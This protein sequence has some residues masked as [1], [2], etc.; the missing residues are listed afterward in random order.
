[1]SI[2][3]DNH[4]KTYNI[5]APN[6]LFRLKNPL[7]TRVK[8]CKTLTGSDLGQVCHIVLD[9]DGK[10]PYAEGQSVGVLTPGY[11]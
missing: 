4:D 5:R 3:N 10:M 7:V 9:T 6:N 1:M 11:D 8:S 2:D